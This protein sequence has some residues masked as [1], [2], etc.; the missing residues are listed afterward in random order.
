MAL[1]KSM[2]SWTDLIDTDPVGAWHAF[3]LWKLN[4]SYADFDNPAVIE[5]EKDRLLSN[6]TVLCEA[7]SEQ[8]ATCRSVFDE[9][10]DQE[11]LRAPYTGKHTRQEVMRCLCYPDGSRRFP[12][13]E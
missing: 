13:V 3:E 9:Q 4:A 7:L 8:L 10:N 6:L 1:V 5:I 12:E 2:T 11:G